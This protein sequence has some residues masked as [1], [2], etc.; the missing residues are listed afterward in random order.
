M[1]LLGEK[2][3]KIEEMKK[4][5]RIILI[6]GLLLLL[7]LVRALL[8]PVL[9]DPLNVYFKNDYLYAAIPTI[10]FGRYFLHLFFRYF[11]NTLFSLA[12]IYL[13]FSNIRL[14]WFSIK[15]YLIAFVVLSLLLF[16][17]LKYQFIDGYM[18]L[19]YVRRFL[20]HPLFVFILLPAFYYQTLQ[21]K[22]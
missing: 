12:I 17:L 15:F 22:K 2:I 18:L 8:A 10:E 21:T 5:V 13:I 20:I 11:L 4:G 3:L 16:L 14:I 1:V 7:I 19:F 6:I 9:Y